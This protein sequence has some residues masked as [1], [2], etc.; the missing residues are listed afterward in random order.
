MAVCTLCSQE[1]TEHVSCSGGP[2]VIHDE[3]FECVRW[4][5]EHAQRRWKPTYD[6]PDCATP[7]GGVH[8]HG[9]DQ[10]ECPKCG[11]QAVWCS[12]ADPLEDEWTG[13]PRHCKAHRSFRLRQ[14]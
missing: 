11:G 9:C 5:T 4:G 14:G 13:D 3:P 2:L 10:E 12:C 6:C 8:H 1:M 7:L